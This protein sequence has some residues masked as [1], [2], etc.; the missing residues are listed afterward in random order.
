MKAA[1]PKGF[2]VK[3][4]FVENTNYINHS[5]NLHRRTVI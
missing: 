4:R 5:S 3:I 1:F 2:A